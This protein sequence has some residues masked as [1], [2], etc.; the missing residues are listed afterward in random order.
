MLL[1]DINMLTLR[2]CRLSADNGDIEVSQARNVYLEDVSF[3]VPEGKVAWK[4]KEGDN[5]NLFVD[6][7]SL[8][9]P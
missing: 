3:E 7:K 4:M 5:E 2:D 6:G 1:N 9:L 8:T